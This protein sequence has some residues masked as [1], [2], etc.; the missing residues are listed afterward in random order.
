MNLWSEIQGSRSGSSN[1]SPLPNLICDTVWVNTV[2]LEDSHTHCLH[3]VY[4]CFHIT[5]GDK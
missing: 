1:C 4:G 3:N 5:K 2:L